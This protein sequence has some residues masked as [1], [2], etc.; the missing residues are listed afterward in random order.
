MFYWT[1][2]IFSNNICLYCEILNC[3][4]VLLFYTCIY[5][6][7]KAWYN[8]TRA[9]T[10]VLSLKHEEIAIKSKFLGP[11]RLQETFLCKFFNHFLRFTTVQVSLQSYRFHGNC[12]QLCF[13][14]WYDMGL[15]QSHDFERFFKSNKCK[16][17]RKLIGVCKL[18]TNK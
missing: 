6:F 7:F 18:C 10:V 9:T 17:R 16:K 13:P 8:R 2:F 3:N 12:P 14:T 15:E 4:Y 11:C 1:F 5:L